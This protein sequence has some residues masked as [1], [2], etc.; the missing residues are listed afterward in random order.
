VPNLAQDM[1]WL[2]FF[3]LLF[4]DDSFDQVIIRLPETLKDLAVDVHVCDVLQTKTLISLTSPFR[5]EYMDLTFSFAS[6]LKLLNS[7]R[8]QP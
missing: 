3:E 7:S 5:C 8:R 6:C 2:Q 1:R 4:I